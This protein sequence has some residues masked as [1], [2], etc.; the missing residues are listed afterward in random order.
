MIFNKMS[1]QKHTLLRENFY[2]NLGP[3][4]GRNDNFKQN[5]YEEIM[6]CG[7]NNIFSTATT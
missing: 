5:K 4:L 7:Q 3:N 2:H 1:M 6:T